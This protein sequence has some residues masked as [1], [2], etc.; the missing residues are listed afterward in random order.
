MRSL[1]RKPLI[2]PDGSFYT[3]WSLM[4]A[5]PMFY[6]AVVTPLYIGLLKDSPLPIF[7]T[8]CVIDTVFII[9]LVRMVIAKCPEA[10]LDP[11]LLRAVQSFRLTS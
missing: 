5:L 11:I 1:K 8:D 9:D 10:T 6:I 4:M 3:Q 7:I 2:Y